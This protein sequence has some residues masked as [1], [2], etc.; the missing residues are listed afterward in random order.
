MEVEMEQRDVERR[1][2]GMRGGWRCSWRRSRALTASRW[3]CAMRCGAMRCARV[4]VPDETSRRRI[5]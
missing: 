1:R 2:R 3:S 4:Q 5:Q